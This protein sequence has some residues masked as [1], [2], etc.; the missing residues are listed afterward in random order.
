MFICANNKMD[1]W[2]IE[3]VLEWAASK[4]LP[5]K[6][7]KILEEQEIDGEALLLLTSDKFQTVGFEKDVADTFSEQIDE[8]QPSIFSSR[9]VNLILSLGE[10]LDELHTQYTSIHKNA[11]PTLE[12][13][14]DRLRIWLKDNLHLA[15][16]DIEAATTVLQIPLLEFYTSPAATDTY[17]M[18][19]KVNRRRPHDPKFEIKTTRS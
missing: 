2:S 8:L 12:Q 19:V 10:A 3:R 5:S 9:E 15:E 17:F 14:N 11:Y 7:I 1:Y 16:G 18:V 13:A 4:G 6:Y